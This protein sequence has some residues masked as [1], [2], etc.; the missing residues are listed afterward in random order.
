MILLRIIDLSHT[1]KRDIPLFNEK[2]P[3]PTCSAWLSHEES[4]QTGNYEGCTCEITEV[5]FVTSIGTYVDSPFH[6]HPD[7]KSI[8]AL[9]LTQLVLDGIVVDCPIDRPRTPIGPRILENSNID[10]KAVLFHTG[11]SQF[12]N[13]PEYKE[14][15]F[16]TEETAIALR[17]GGASMVGVDFLTVDDQNNP[18]RPAHTVLLGRDILIVENLTGMDHLPRTKFTFH[19]VPVKFAGAAAFPVRA[20]AIT[21]DQ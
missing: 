1:I 10:G 16:L 4:A 11:W 19:A 17:D 13:S 8:E 3:S 7:L 6:F 2:V 9:D 12:W 15:P 20:Y 5:Q 18:R 21:D 14:S